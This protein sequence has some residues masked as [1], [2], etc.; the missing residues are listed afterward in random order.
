MSTYTNVNNICIV[1]NKIQEIIDQFCT[2]QKSLNQ[3]SQCCVLQYDPTK[4]WFKTP[5][6]FKYN[7]PHF[8]Q[9]QIDT[10]Q[11]INN[12]TSYLIV[13]DGP[14]TMGIV[15]TIR[16]VTKDPV[17]ILKNPKNQTTLFET[18]LNLQ[19]N[20]PVKHVY[21]IT[22]LENITKQINYQVNQLS[23][24]QPIPFKVKTLPA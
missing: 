8:K 20:E 4:S 6:Q 21:I 16:A 14:E 3:E 2:F 23:R 22:H 17:F 1:G 11:I 15:K 18:T 5:K 24:K 13:N 12:T 19:T 10:N 7:S 9:E